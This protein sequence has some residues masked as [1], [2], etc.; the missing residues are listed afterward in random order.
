MYLSRLM[1]N[2]RARRVRAEIANPYEMHRTLSRAFSGGAFSVDRRR[3]IR[4]RGSLPPGSAPAQRHPDCAGAVADGT[5]LV[6]PASCGGGLPVGRRRLAG[7]RPNPAVKPVDLRLAP[8]QVLAFRL[9]ANPTVKKS[10]EDHNQGRREGL[11][12]EEDQLDWLKRKVE[13][14]GGVLLSANLTLGRIRPRHAAPRP[15][16]TRAEFPGGAV[17]RGAAGAQQSRLVDAVQAGFRQ[18]QGVWLRPALAGAGTL[19]NQ[20]DLS[21]GHSPAQAI[22]EWENRNLQQP[23]RAF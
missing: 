15:A 20:T 1:L 18:R 17:R 21:P 3:G 4:R 2:P 14:A 5:G 11:L 10:R 8:G 19:S 12:R 22:P 6:P 9:R 13:A 16:K 7:G 23:I